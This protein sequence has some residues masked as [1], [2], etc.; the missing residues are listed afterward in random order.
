MRRIAQIVVVVAFA[1]TGTARAAPDPQEVPAC[2]QRPITFRE[3]IRLGTGQGYEPGIEIDSVG[4]IFV[5]AHKRSITNEGNRLSSW[6][7]RSTD[8]GLTFQ[9]MGGLMGATDKA[10]AFEGDLAVD[11]KD[12]LYYVDTWLADNH[13][14]RFA[15][16]GATLDMF[17]PAVPTY[18][19]DDRPWL[20]AH[21]DGYVYYLSN[22]GYKHD[23]RLTIH[24]STDG[25]L[26]WDVG[27]TF[28]RSGW[29]FID[30]D[31]NS[32]YVYGFM[33]DLFYGT[34]V[35]GN[36]T[37]LFAWISADRGATWKQVKVAD[38]EVGASGAG[39]PN[40]A[41]SPVDGAVYTIWLD[42]D[43]RIRM[44]RSTDHGTTWTVYEVA[45]F[46]G[47][48]AYPWVTVGPTGDVGIVFQ[49]DPAAVTGGSSFVYGM[50]WRPESDCLREP[51]DPAS[52]CTGPASNYARLQATRAQDQADFFQG[53]F[54]A[55]NALNAPFTDRSNS[56]DQPIRYTRQAGGPN[57]DGTPFCG[58]V[59]RP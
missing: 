6:I 56:Q 32:D 35:L 52:V 5:T 10:F 12:R 31:P 11:A 40:V 45:P 25:G 2:D 21:H 47:R 4:T 48:F 54:S 44:G 22:T 59:G 7:W 34:G 55:D 16:H 30:A 19:V 58:I 17:R 36:G 46:K 1:S 41:V 14:Y 39:F 49:A 37:A 13:F 51:A 33:D 28:A 42:G 15:D 27:F 18:E 50:V 29:G 38:Y 57:M 53:E 3:P 24:R 26:T 23:G 43:E 20:A 9:D 8:A